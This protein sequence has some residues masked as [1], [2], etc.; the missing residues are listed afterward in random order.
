MIKLILNNLKKII[1][2]LS[3]IPL[4]VILYFPAKYVY[5]VYYFGNYFEHNKKQLILVKDYIDKN[6][7]SGSYDANFEYFTWSLYISCFKWET[8]NLGNGMTVQ[9][10]M[11]KIHLNS[12]RAYDSWYPGDLFIHAE[13]IG[14]SWIEFGFDKIK[15]WETSMFVYYSPWFF[16]GKKEGDY[17]DPHWVQIIIEK[18][19]N[20][21]WLIFWSY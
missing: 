6:K 21:W 4:I 5:E 11:K 13:N 20:D 19:N 16:N 17:L 18:Y 15:I 8:C 2:F 12:I 10:M 9:N 14:T 3:I 1:I 7:L